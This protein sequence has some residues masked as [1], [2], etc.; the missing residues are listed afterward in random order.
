MQ[1][2]IALFVLF[3]KQ[4]IVIIINQAPKIKLRDWI[5]EGQKKNDSIISLFGSIVRD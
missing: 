3:K 5:Q 1:Y 4:I 2:F